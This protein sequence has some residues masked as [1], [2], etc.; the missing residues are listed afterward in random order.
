MMGEG[1]SPL[2]YRGESH[3]QHFAA[4]TCCPWLCQRLETPATRILKRS[5]PSVMTLAE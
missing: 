2:A 5:E 1:R 3:F 4:V